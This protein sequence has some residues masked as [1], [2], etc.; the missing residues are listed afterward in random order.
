[1]METYD[2]VKDFIDYITAED[3]DMPYGGLVNDAPKSAKEAYEKY[4]KI[5][6][7]LESQ[8]IKE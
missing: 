5:Q 1:M 6:N 7:K 8:N 4:V 3:N 2:A